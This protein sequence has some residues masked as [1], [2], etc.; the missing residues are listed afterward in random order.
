R[1]AHAGVPLREEELLERRRAAPA[2]LPRPVKA[3]PAAVV[4]R[5]L[6]PPA[7]R[8]LL[9]RLRRL[10][11]SRRSPALGQIRDQPVVHL[12]PETL[13]GGGRAEIHRATVVAEAGGGRQA[14]R[15]SHACA[16]HAIERCR[17]SVPRAFPGDARSRVGSCEGRDEGLLP[18]HGTRP[19]SAG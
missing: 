8:D 3:G 19:R 12:A 7:E 10:A 13:L 15:A 1:R 2:V 14:T 9:R 16:R 4:E 18:L 5:A 11:V 17:E 6:P